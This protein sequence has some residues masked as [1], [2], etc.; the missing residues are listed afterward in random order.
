MFSLGNDGQQLNEEYH[1]KRQEFLRSV[2]TI[3]DVGDMDIEKYDLDDL[4]A[5]NQLGGPDYQPE[6]IQHPEGE[7]ETEPEDSFDVRD[8]PGH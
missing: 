2:P 3:D 6:Y 4:P 8:L 1:T 7:A 5:G